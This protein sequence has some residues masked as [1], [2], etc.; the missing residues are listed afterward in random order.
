MPMCGAN[1]ANGFNTQPP[2]GGWRSSESQIHRDRQFQHTAARRRLGKSCLSSL[3]S[4]MF[5]HTAARR[6]LALPPVVM[7][8]LKNVSTHSRP[9]A[10]GW[11]ERYVKAH[12]RVSTHSRPKAAGSRRAWPSASTAVSTHSR[13]KAAGTAPK[14]FATVLLG[15]NTQP[16]EGGWSSLHIRRCRLPVSTHSRPKA[17]GP[18]GK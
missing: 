5:Q 12:R 10:A 7:S 13:P 16:P 1:R 15:F 8:C 14:P 3:V 17:A 2:E 9:K 6:R 18:N 4:V 11:R